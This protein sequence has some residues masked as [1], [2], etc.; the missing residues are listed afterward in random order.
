MVVSARANSCSAISNVF[1]AL[2][3]CVGIK[4]EN[5]GAG[6]QGHSPPS[7]QNTAQTPIGFVTRGANFDATSRIADL[8]GARNVECARWELFDFVAWKSWRA[9]RPRTNHGSEDG[10]AHQGRKATW[11]FSGDGLHTECRRRCVGSLSEGTFGV[12]GR[13]PMWHVDHR[14]QQ[15]KRA[16]RGRVLESVR[17]ASRP[18]P[19]PHLHTHTCVRVCRPLTPA[20]GT[21]HVGLLR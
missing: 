21:I 7:R 13:A 1:C 20:H 8:C 9:T 19:P 6:L 5:N 17:C 14:Y 3:I 15:Q 4:K 16:H 11:P 10:T 2:G 18:R 12:R